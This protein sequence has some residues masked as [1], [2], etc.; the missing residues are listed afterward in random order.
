MKIV[1]WNCNMAFRKKKNRILQHNP[2]VLI[3]QECE[4]PETKGNWDEF[5]DWVWI[6][7]NKNKG[8]GIFARNETK[9]EMISNPNDYVSRYIILVNI[10]GLRNLTLY[11]FWAMN[12]KID[13]KKRYIGQVYTALQHYKDFLG[14]ETIIAGD[15]NWNIIWDRSTNSTLYGNFSDTIELLKHKGIFSIYHQQNNSDFGDENTPTFFMYKK[16][17][18]PYHIDYIFSSK[19]LIELVTD[20]WIGKYEEWVDISDHVPIMVEIEN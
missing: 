14:T 10:M 7:D 15:F 19:E 6:G 11:G 18:K 2:D 1:T 16:L 17:N 13:R 5:S 3:I 4:N 9:I 20:F 12:D 8:L